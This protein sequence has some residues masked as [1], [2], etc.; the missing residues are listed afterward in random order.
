[1]G[2]L[3]WG[4]GIDPLREGQ[5]L[6]G[7]RPCDALIQPSF[8]DGHWYRGPSLCEDCEADR[9]S[10]LLADREQEWRE[11]MDRAKWFSFK[12]EI[13]RYHDSGAFVL[14]PDYGD[15]WVDL[16]DFGAPLDPT[17]GYVGEIKIPR[18]IARKKGVFDD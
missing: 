5:P 16:S 2:G 6:E 17:P 13:G 10:E 12:G 11:G 15:V 4:I 9:A 7:K 18:W 3:L 14:I 8:W 1:M